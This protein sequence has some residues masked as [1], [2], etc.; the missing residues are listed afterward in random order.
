MMFI[1]VP[2]SAWLLAICRYAMISEPCSRV[3]TIRPSC[4]AE[5][6]CL[7]DHP[8]LIVW[9]DRDLSRRETVGLNSRDIHVPQ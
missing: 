5:A 9:H 7:Q 2:H 4:F 6:A 3:A 1:H 8:H